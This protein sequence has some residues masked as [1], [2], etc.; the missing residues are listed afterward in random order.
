MLTFDASIYDSFILF[1]TLEGDMAVRLKWGDNPDFLITIGGFHP[2]YTP[3]PLALPTLRRLAINILNTAIASIRVE[4][5]QAVTS[6]TVQFGARADISFD[7]EVCAIKGDIGFDALFQFNPFYFIVSVSANFTLSAVGIDILSVHIRMSLEGPTPWRAKGTGSVSILFF[8]ISADFDITWGDA[9]NTSLPTIKILP[10]FIKELNKRENWNTVLSTG[11]NLLITLRKMDEDETNL[12]L[13]PAGSL[14][15]QQKLLPIK[16]EFDKVGSNKTEDIKKV[17]V[18]G[19]EVDGN[20][21]QVTDV[22][23]YFARAQFQTLSD[24][25]K[26]SKPSFEQ[27]PGGASISSNDNKAQNGKMVRKNVEYEITIIDKEPRK[28]FKRGKFYRDHDILFTH[29]LDGGSVSKSVLSKS[30]QSKLKPFDEK[31]TVAQEGFSV[32][33]QANNKAFTSSATFASEME[34]NTFLNQQLRNNPNLKKDL[35][36][37]PNHELQEI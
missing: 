17:E 27:M 1:M 16:V 2:S 30:Y 34:A 36:I 4:C 3:P 6:N 19:A 14:V 23:E 7:L 21:L 24:A 33:F 26:L 11:K 28:P 5:Y 31:M 9:S 32:A 37:I 8:E 25:E 20:G 35:H 15:V 22:N 12:V 13:H 10:E 18:T 29:F